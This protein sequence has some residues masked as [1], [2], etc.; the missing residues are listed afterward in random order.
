MDNQCPKCGEKL[1][2][3]YFKPECPKCGCN[4]MYYNMESRLEADAKAV[5]EESI[6]L[7]RLLPK[8][9]QRKQEKKQNE[10]VEK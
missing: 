6:R 8:W 9:I 4:I 2:L 3:L 10:N 1:K 7:K 5:E